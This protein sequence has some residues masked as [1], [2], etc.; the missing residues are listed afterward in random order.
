MSTINTA[1]VGAHVE[2]LVDVIRMVLQYNQL[3]FATYLVLYPVMRSV[4]QFEA[5]TVHRCLVLF[6][7]RFPCAVRVMLYRSHGIYHR[8]YASFHE[9]RDLRTSPVS[10]LSVACRVRETLQGNRLLARRVNPIKC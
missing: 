7:R 3:P 1:V 8:V 10:I 4:M 2:L 5:V 9:R 6:I